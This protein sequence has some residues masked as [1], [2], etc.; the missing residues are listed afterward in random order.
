MKETLLLFLF[1]S[2][3]QLVIHLIVL[4]ILS[5]TNT[6][7]IEQIYYHGRF[8]VLSF[9]EKVK[10]EYVSVIFRSQNPVPQQEENLNFSTLCFP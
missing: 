1:Q 8:K 5:A 7:N 4:F 3:Q 9:S 6:T 10:Q 2:I